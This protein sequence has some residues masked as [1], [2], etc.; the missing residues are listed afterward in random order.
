MC[1][2][3]EELVSDQCYHLILIKRLPVSDEKKGNMWEFFPKG[4]GGAPVFQHIFQFINIKCEIDHN[5]F[6]ENR[7][8]P[9]GVG[10][11]GIIVPTFSRFS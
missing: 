3:R 10:Q 4:G 1:Y 8:L 6:L 9:R 11:V 5:F 7:V 2:N